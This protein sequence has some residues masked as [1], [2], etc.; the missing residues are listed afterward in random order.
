MIYEDAVV[1]VFPDST[2]AMVSPML[3][4]D[5]NVVSVPYNVK[6]GDTLF[7]IANLA[8]GD[9]RA[10]FTIAEF[11]FENIENPFELTLGQTLY[12]PLPQ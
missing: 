8:Y 5:K 4:P 1:V 9:T 3:A 7:S 2:K 11:N 6:D 10:W 12:L